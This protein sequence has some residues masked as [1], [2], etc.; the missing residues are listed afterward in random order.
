MAVDYIIINNRF[1]KGTGVGG[2]SV[3]TTA[4]YIVDNAQMARRISTQCSVTEAD[5]VAVLQAYE[6]NLK[7]AFAEGNSVRMF[8]LGTLKPCFKAEFDNKGN[9]VKDSLRMSK[10]QLITAHT[11]INEAKGYEYRY[12]GEQEDYCPDFSGRVNNMLDYFA[13]GFTEITAREYVYINDCSKTQACDDLRM[14]FEEGVLSRRSYGNCKV[15][16]LN[17]Y[18]QKDRYTIVVDNDK[19]DLT[20]NVDSDEVATESL[21]AEA[22]VVEKMIFN[23]VNSAGESRENYNIYNNDLH[24]IINNDSTEKS[25]NAE[26]E[27]CCNEENST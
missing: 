21:S 1:R 13:Q 26:N 24:A 19:K 20:N 7:M 25:E 10:V 12:H 27:G 23:K 17:N 3:K 9:I 2:R 8:N 5:I 15:Y 11:F 18:D 4:N 14:L 22:P 16:M 6:T